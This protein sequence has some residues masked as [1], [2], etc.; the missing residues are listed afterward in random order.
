MADSFCFSVLIPLFC[1]LVIRV[2][3]DCGGYIVL[4]F[5]FLFQGSCLECLGLLAWFSLALVP[6]FA[7]SSGLVLC[8]LVFVCSVF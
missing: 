7:P 3:I 1:A 2:M 8:I 4:S 5:S 6:I